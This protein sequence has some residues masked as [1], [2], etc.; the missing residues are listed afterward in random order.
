L[1]CFFEDGI[2]VE[3]DMLNFPDAGDRER[4]S[5]SEEDEQFGNMS[6]QLTPS[7]FFYWS[8]QEPP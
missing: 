4:E 8:S 5:T 1:K 7:R 6:L 3:A 2:D